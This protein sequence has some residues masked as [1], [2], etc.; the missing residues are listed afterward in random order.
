MVGE[1][2]KV[3]WRRRTVAVLLALCTPAGA[4][5][6]AL[7]WW[8]RGLAWFLALLLLQ[9]SL[10]FTGVAGAALMVV[11]QLGSI[12]D[13][14]LLRPS[15]RGLPSTGR[16]AL[17]A[18]AFLLSGQAAA[19]LNRRFI[20]EPFWVPASSMEP[21]LLQ[22]DQFVADRTVRT[23]WQ[24]QPIERGSIIVFP[25]PQKPEQDFVKRVVARGGDTV[26]LRNGVVLLNGQPLERKWVG[27]CES[28]EGPTEGGGCEEYEEV[29]GSRRYRVRHDLAFAHEGRF[30][31]EDGRCPQGLEP[32]DGGC[33]VP[34]G[35]LFVLG[36]NRTNSYDSRFWGGVPE[37][38][39]KGMA[40]SVHFSLGPDWHV[41][42]ERLG[43]PLR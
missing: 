31:A 4:G 18:V 30:P 11:L 15:S 27:S 1:A 19:R 9:A 38:S 3:G 28:A 34:V 26:A 6:G 12:I 39:V 42:W 32:K 43:Q 29:L 7:G 41:R 17:L 14:A 24:W 37:L 13:V 23:P 16:A 8:Q 20:A 21:T 2:G 36:D 22:G 10:L 5:H 40:V 25:D 35:Q 33:A